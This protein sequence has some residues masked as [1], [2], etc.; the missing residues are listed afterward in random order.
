[1]RLKIIKL[2]KWKSIQWILSILTIGIFIIWYIG[3]FYQFFNATVQQDFSMFQ[4]YGEIALTLFGFT[5]IGGIFEKNKNREKIELNLFDTSL[6]FLAVAMAFFFMYSLS[7]V[8]SK[9]IIPFSLNYMSLV[10]VISFACA[11]LIGF[12]GFIAGF[13]R[14][15]KILIDY[16]ISI[17]DKIKK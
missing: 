2:N 10:V 12:V 6:S 3:F 1:M 8:F 11:M 4:I 15:Y 14:L 17:E 7:G 9:E 5:L 13:L 16:R